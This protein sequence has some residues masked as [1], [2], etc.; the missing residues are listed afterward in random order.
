MSE[1]LYEVYSTR[2]VIK[3]SSPKARAAIYTC[4]GKRRSDSEV[5]SSGLRGTNVVLSMLEEKYLRAEVFYD[6]HNCNNN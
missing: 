2:I 3:R 5:K 1:W 6:K 4:R